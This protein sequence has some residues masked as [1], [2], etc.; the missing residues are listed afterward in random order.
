MKCSHRTKL[1]LQQLFCITMSTVS[2]NIC[3]RFS[4][5]PVTFLLTQKVF[6]AILKINKY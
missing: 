3:P 1:Q 6:T 2:K 5:Y 4:L